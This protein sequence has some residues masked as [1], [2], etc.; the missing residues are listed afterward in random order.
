MVDIAL[1]QA[2]G[3]TER[4]TLGPPSSL[5]RHA[6]AICDPHG[7][8]RRP[9]RGRP[10]R[11]VEPWR[12]PADR[13]G[14]DAGLPAP[15]LGLGFKIAEAMDTSQRGMGL[16]WANAAEL[17]SR[18]LTRREQPGADLACGAGTDQLD[19]AGEHTLD[20]VIAA[21]EEQIAHV[22]R[23]GGRII[24]MA[25]RALCRAARKR[26]GLPLPSMAG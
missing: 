26:R 25:S 21:Y 4:H 22:E 2:G 10:A 3:G 12:K 19:P 8:C 1:P 6:C 18:V 9:C 15:S 11:A 16:D 23:H 24:L 7:L 5:P 13:L 20:E 17:I 14:R